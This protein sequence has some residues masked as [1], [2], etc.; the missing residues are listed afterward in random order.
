[1]ARKTEPERLENIYD[2]IEDYPGK[3]PGFL[4]RIL[5]LPRSSITRTLPTMEEEGY[6]LSED[7]NGGL[8]PFSR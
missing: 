5:N 7:Q 2:S 1:M 4:A 6:L 3:R 8:W